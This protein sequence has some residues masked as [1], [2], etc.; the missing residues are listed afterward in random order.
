MLHK[1]DALFKQIEEIA[2]LSTNTSTAAKL[3]AEI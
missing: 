2:I 3:W 1:T